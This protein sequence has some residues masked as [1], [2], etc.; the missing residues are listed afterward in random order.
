MHA[1]K[2][3]PCLTLSS[4]VVIGLARYL[5][6]EDHYKEALRLQAD[7][8]PHEQG[9]RSQL[10]TRL[11]QVEQ[12]LAQQ[13]RDT[14]FRRVGSTAELR[15]MLSPKSKPAVVCQPSYEQLAVDNSRFKDLSSGRLIQFI[16]PLYHSD[17]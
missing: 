9:L 11:K 15:A 6:A 10:Q 4:Y 3:R 16:A 2:D 8:L 14:V 7:R 17:R 1:C 12:A 5:R 13:E